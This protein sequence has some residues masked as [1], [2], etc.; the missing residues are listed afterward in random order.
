M[1]KHRRFTWRK[2]CIAMLSCALLVP[3]WGLTPDVA[4]AAEPGENLLSNGGFEAGDGTWEKWGSPEVVAGESHGGTQSML[5]RNK[6]GGASSTVLVEEGKTYTIGLWVKLAAGG[7]DAA[8]IGVGVNTF[9]DETQTIALPFT[10]STDWEYK[11]LQLTIDAAVKSVR[12]AFWNETGIDYYLDDAV[13]QEKVNAKPDAP[14]GLSATHQGQSL[15]LSWLASTDDSGVDH[16]EIAYKTLGTESSWTTETADAQPVQERYTHL[17]E[18]LA[19]QTLYAIKIAAVDEEGL[20]SDSPMIVAGTAGANLLADAGFESGTTGDWEVWEA[21]M[22]VTSSVYHSGNYA[23]EV[24]SGSGGASGTVSIEPGRSY[25]VGFW[26]QADGDSGNN[27]NVS[28]S[29]FGPGAD[30]T[31][32]IPITATTEWQYAELVHESAGQVGARI[33]IWNDTG[34]KYAVDDVWI[35][36][37]PAVPDDLKPSVPGNL[38]AGDVTALTAELQWEPSTDELGVAEY[39]VSYRRDGEDDWTKL[40]VPADRQDSAYVYKVTGLSPSSSYTFRVAAR[41]EAGSLSDPASVAANTLQMQPIDPN[42]SAEARALLQRLYD[43]TGKQIL[44][45]QHN[46][47]EEPNVWYDKA[48]ELTGYYPGLWGSDFAFYTSGD[49]QALRAAMVDAAID[50]WNGGVVVALTFHQSWPEDGP[51]AG[52]DSVTM[53]RTEAEMEELVTPGTELYDAWAAQVDEVAEHLKVLRDAGVPVL[54]RPYHEM[55]AN[56]FWWGGRPELFKQLW[57]NLYDRFTNDHGLNNLIWVWNPNA[58][59]AWS[60]D[61]AP[62]YPGGDFVDALAADIYNNDYQQRHYDELLRLGEGRPIGIGENGELPNIEALRASQPRYAWF[63]TWPEFLTN[64]NSLATIQSVFSHPY[65]LNNGET[66]DGPYVP[67]VAERYI[68]D[69]FEGYA[70]SDASLQGKWSRNASGNILTVAL[71]AEHKQGGQYGMRL[72]YTIGDPGFSGAYKIYADSWTGAQGIRFWLQPDGSNRVLTVQFHE[73]D[74]EVW[75][76]GLSLTGTQARIV[77][78][79]FSEFAHPGWYNGGNSVVDPEAIKEFA[80]YFGQGEG[81]P[82]SGTIYVDDIEAVKSLDDEGG[83]GGEEDQDSNGSG[84]NGGVGS[85]GGGD[86]GNDDG[87]DGGN[88]SGVVGT[89]NGDKGAIGGGAANDAAPGVSI[90][91][92]AQEQI[93]AIERQQDGDRTT[94]IVTVDNDQ[95]LALL[96]EQ[97]VQTLTLRAGGNGGDAGDDVV[98]VVGGNLLQA[99]ADQG[100]AIE[101]RTDRASYTLPASLIDLPSFARQLGEDISP[102]DV[103][104][105]IEVSEAPAA[106]DAALTE[107]AAAAGMS[108]TVRPIIFEIKLGYGDKT[109]TVSRFDGF[110]QRGLTLPDDSDPRGLAGIVL[111][112]DGTISPVPIRVVEQDGVLIA[113][114]NSLT[115]SAYAVAKRDGASMDAGWT[116]HWGGKDFADLVDRWVI[117]AEEGPSKRPDQAVSRAEFVLATARAFGL[118]GGEDAA[119]VK[120][121]DVQRDGAVADAIRS[122]IRYGWI[123]GYADGTFRPDRTITRAE[124]ASILA[125]AMEL[126]G[127]P[128]DLSEGDIGRTL[129]PFRDGGEVAQWARPAVAAAVRQGILQ[130][131]DARLHPN[132]NITWAETAAVIRRALAQAG[133]IDAD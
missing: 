42:A 122:A 72:D 43:L 66:G 113:I 39:E 65:T 126:A 59:N 20:K 117:F 70:G 49:I 63:M 90:D 61:E 29:F 57:H 31:I 37:L 79:P 106:I 103:T 123:R 131:Y 85:N 108:L 110:V 5:V 86:G 10:G 62:Y 35:A 83:D 44:S 45:G 100:A 64:N 12:I 98:G 8:K 81:E 99:L 116:S 67:P 111:H 93:A 16:Y 19:P 36:E 130:G 119:D 114:I 82:G 92:V 55:N 115:N 13:I 52:W 121:Q 32:P 75:E 4:S 51:T 60:F 27:A 38:S 74:G 95:A 34:V 104:I 48:A 128:A 84:D 40:G 68:I 88:G 125:A 7:A 89:G 11:E 56:F 80:F 18:G 1:K 97:P 41:N 9:G 3:M 26:I 78:I 96:G 94:V 133:L 91:G 102:G 33:N 127:V 21:R 54:W 58:R 112:N 71:D 77:T 105:R 120:L 118:R 28:A 109:V 14:D 46:Y 76:A 101:L 73:T 87:G 17:L 6:N 50:H 132:G 22:T 53:N 25:V 129:D 69:D 24:P 23:L 124:A 2:L 107:A 47:Y 15:L 30:A